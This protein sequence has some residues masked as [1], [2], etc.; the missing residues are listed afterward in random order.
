MT[1]SRFFDIDLILAE[2]EKVQLEMQLDAYKLDNLE[3]QLLNLEG[4]DELEKKEENDDDE[5]SVQSLIEQKNHYMLNG[6]LFTSSL[7]LALNLAQFKFVQIQLPKWYNTDYMNIMLADPIVVN[8]KEKNCNFFDLGLIVANSL[9]KNNI[10]ENLKEIFI[11]R[12]K[13]IIIIVL[14][15]N[16]DTFNSSFLNKLC[17]N[18]NDIYEIAKNSIIEYRLWKTGAI[19]K[20]NK[21]NVFT[22]R[23]RIKKN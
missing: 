6:T 2:E 16:D 4:F 7:W 23:K 15:Q 22:T 19:L 20:Q 1:E 10:K 18:E 14:H 8:L 11:E 3:Y 5:N 17:N 9:K 21:H 13:N 12:L